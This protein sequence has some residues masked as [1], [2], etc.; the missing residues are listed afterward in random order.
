M[1]APSA[2]S[3]SRT[4]SRAGVLLALLLAVVMGLTGCSLLEAPA[5]R[6]VAPAQ[7]T[8]PVSGLDWVDQDTLPDEAQETLELI[9]VGGP[10]PYDKDGTVFGNREELLPDREHGYYHEYTVVTPGESDRGARRIVTGGDDEY[11]WTADHYASFE[12]IRRTA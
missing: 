9:D 8:D 2:E 1:T 4:R 6:P 5:E 7:A 10:F 3:S 12:R 11:Y